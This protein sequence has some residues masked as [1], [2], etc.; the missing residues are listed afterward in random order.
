M[1]QQIKGLCVCVRLENA[2]TSYQTSSSSCGSPIQKSQSYKKIWDLQ[3]NNLTFFS[4]S[5]DL[6]G[7]GR[8]ILCL[9]N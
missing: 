9:V 2:V 3:K 6:C 1:F 7:D 5:C 8:L 4:V